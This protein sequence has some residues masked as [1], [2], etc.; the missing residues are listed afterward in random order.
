MHRRVSASRRLNAI[1]TAAITLL[2]VTAPAHAN[3]SGGG[4]GLPWESALQ[5]LVVSFTGP[6]MQGVLVLAIVALGFAVMWS[7][8]P[9]LRRAFG[10]LLG[11][12]IAAAAVSIALTLFGVSGATF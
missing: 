12:A 2:F 5:K 8:G 6:V 4:S 3:T 10:L 11:G 7:E 1:F 9:V